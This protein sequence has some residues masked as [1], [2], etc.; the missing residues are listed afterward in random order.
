[1]SQCRRCIY[2]V[3]GKS[4]QN[5]SWVWCGVQTEKLLLLWKG[6]SSEP[7][8]GAA[9]TNLQL[10]SKGNISSAPSTVAESSAFCKLPL[11]TLSVSFWWPQPAAVN[12]ETR[13]DTLGAGDPA[14]VPI[15]PAGHWLYWLEVWVGKIWCRVGRRKYMEDADNLGCHGYLSFTWCSCFGPCWPSHQPTWKT[16]R[17]SA[18]L[19]FV[20]TNEGY[21][22]AGAKGT[23]GTL[24]KNWFGRNNSV[25]E[26]HILPEARPL[27][28]LYSW[29]LV[30]VLCLTS[31]MRSWLS[32]PFSQQCWKDCQVE[33]S[34]FCS[35]K[36]A[37]FKSK[38]TAVF[39]AVESGI[40]W[41]F[42]KHPADVTAQ[43]LS[44]S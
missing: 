43:P 24:G 35:L 17:R 37:S 33:S 28:L 21:P 23:C 8:P 26:T 4:G 5:C 31:R 38:C 12:P 30:T 29:R 36:T 3:P 15:L 40:A 16:T 42:P 14:A 13:Q 32:F 9:S 27:A 22:V 10:W 41:S 7:K 19:H 1:M 25:A 6:Y 18:H 34:P 11:S 44:C 39:H 2:Q 20:Q